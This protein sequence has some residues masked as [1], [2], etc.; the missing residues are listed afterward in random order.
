MAKGKNREADKLDEAARKYDIE[1]ERATLGACLVLGEVPPGIRD[2]LAPEDFGPGHSAIF[3]EML[4]LQEKGIPLD[5]VTLMDGLQDAGGLDAIGGAAYLAELPGA[6][7]DSTNAIFYA[8]QVKDKATRRGVLAALQNGARL[9]DRADDPGAALAEI[10]A[11]LAGLG[12]LDVSLSEGWQWLTLSDALADR[13]PRVYVVEGLLALPSLSIL[14][15][16]PSTLKT[17]L[18]VDL[19]V[20]VASGFP[21]LL[22]L[23]DALI[24]TTRGVL[25]G[26]VLYCDFDSGRDEMDLR[27][28]AAAR[29]RGAS[30]DMP[31]YYVALPSPWLDSSDWGSAGMAMIRDKA[32]A[33]GAVYIII[34]NLSTVGGSADQNSPDMGPV[35]SNFRRLSETL[36]CAVTVSHHQ[37][38]STGRKDR[39]GE[40]LRGWGGIEGAIDLALLIDR[41]SG[42]D[43]VSIKATKV[44][45]APVVPFGAM[46]TYEHQPGTTDLQEMRFYGLAIED[47]ESD[48]AIKAAILDAVADDP[49]IAKTA[50]TGIIKDKLA[51][52]GRRRIRGQIDLLTTSGKLTM[53]DGAH[54]SK[55]YQL[56]L[57]L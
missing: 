40:S 45:G 35:M 30:E 7:R 1:A 51:D 8:R 14:Y 34:E 22:P 15:G 38:K 43:S 48:G 52:V 11:E 24:D 31:F 26:S 41:E 6:C 44:R 19:G 5:F 23:P 12:A 20:C 3:W 56:P 36:R 54:G 32:E 53:Q 4:R 16:A 25:Q 37:R 47:T 18:L 57:A 13:P 33:V 28:A 27:I 10:Q 21:W 9:I 29:V 39:A 46:F 50:L 42:S 55:R 17:N 49:G 2:L